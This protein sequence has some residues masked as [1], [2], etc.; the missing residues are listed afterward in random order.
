[1]HRDADGR[2][3]LVQL[4]NAPG[5]IGDIEHFSSLPFVDDFLALR[6][7]QLLVL[8]PELF[9]TLVS[10]DETARA[11]YLRHLAAS[12]AVARQ[13]QRCAINTLE[14]RT[15]NL[16]VSYA[17]VDGGPALSELSHGQIARALGSNPRSIA[18][19]L[20]ALQ[21]KGCVKRDRQGLC[22]A[23]PDEMRKARGPISGGVRYQIGMQLTN[24]ERPRRRRTAELTILG[25]PRPIVG[26]S[27]A[28]D[29]ELT[30]GRHPNA[31]LA[32][33]ED[34][35]SPLH[36]RI[37][38]GPRGDRFWIQDLGSGNGCTVNER[39][40]N[41]ARLLD[42]DTIAVGNLTIRVTI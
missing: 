26:Q 21:K 41:R 39:Q 20:A 3:V 9:E 10:E 38:R 13:G 27:I 28:V 16:M 29:D 6:D 23:D 2:E 8:H 1:M 19:V 36:C 30:I 34:S 18:R 35:L 14:Q 5:I 7:A 32:V 25:G 42:G 12:V 37:Y 4:I 31:G 40:V 24:I 15:A 11:V 22:V 17:E 33:A